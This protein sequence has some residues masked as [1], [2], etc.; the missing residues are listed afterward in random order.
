MS[1]RGPD[2]P[3]YTLLFMCPRGHMARSA[4]HGSWHDPQ[5][6]SH[7]VWTPHQTFHA[8]SSVLWVL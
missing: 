5:S 4:S 8:C 2:Q 1:L 3:Q 7:V 6:Q